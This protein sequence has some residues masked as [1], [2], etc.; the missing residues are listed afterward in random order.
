M[1]DTI[2][3]NRWFSRTTIMLFLNKKDLFEKKIARYSLC[4]CF[5]EYADENTYE[6]ASEYIR[7]KFEELNRTPERG[8]F[9]HFTCGIDSENINFVTQI[10][11]DSIIQSRL[12]TYGLY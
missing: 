6:A 11:C 9:S 1:F 10:V 4:V 3:N 7:L 5:P 8:I 2:A 12:K